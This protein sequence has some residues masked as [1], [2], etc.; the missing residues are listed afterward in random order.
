LEESLPD[1][2]F[3]DIRTLGIATPGNK[4]SDV[5]SD[6][7]GPAQELRAA[8]LGRFWASQSW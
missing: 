7:N 1:I 3:S 8:G 2:T 6:A 4:E 5:S